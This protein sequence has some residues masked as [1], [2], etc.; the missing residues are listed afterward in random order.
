VPPARSASSDHPD[1]KLD[2]DPPYVIDAEGF[3]RMKPECL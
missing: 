2:C 1:P 3:H